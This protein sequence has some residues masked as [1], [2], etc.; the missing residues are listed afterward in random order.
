MTVYA[1]NLGAGRSFVELETCER[2]RAQWQREREALLDTIARL[3]AETD[4][5]RRALW[6]AQHPEQTQI[7]EI[8]Q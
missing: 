6:L 4:H 5:L 1:G 8:A 7:Q 3:M 2:E